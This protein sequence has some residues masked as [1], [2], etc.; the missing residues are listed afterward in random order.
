LRTRASK[1]LV[2]DA[3]RLVLVLVHGNMG[4]RANRCHRRQALAWHQVTNGLKHVKCEDGVNEVEADKIPLR[5]MTD[6]WREPSAV[7]EC[8]VEQTVEKYGPVAQNGALAADQLALL[9]EFAVGW[10][11]GELLGSYTPRLGLLQIIAAL[12]CN[13]L[14]FALLDVELGVCSVLGILDLVDDH[15]ILGSGTV[16]ASVLTT[17]IEGIDLL[18]AVGVVVTV[19]FVEKWTIGLCTVAKE[20]EIFFVAAGKGGGLMPT[21]CDG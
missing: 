7:P 11:F 1:H 5:V 21:H 10:Y 3:L 19:H 2:I 8:I 14:E 16:E 17:L 12:K 9:L 18:G 6:P 13:R 20:T 15:T 4:V